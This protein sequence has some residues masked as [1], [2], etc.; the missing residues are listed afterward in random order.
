MYNKH[1]LSTQDIQ[2][3]VEI[4]WEQRSELPAN[5]RIGACTAINGKVYCEGEEKRYVDSENVSA[6][7]FIICYNPSTADWTTLPYLPIKKVGLGAINGQLV[8]VGGVDKNDGESTSDVYTYDDEL[9]R[10]KRTIPPMPT[11]RQSPSVLSL[12]SALIVAGGINLNTFADMVT[13]EV[14]RLD[15]SQWYRTDPLLVACRGISLVAIGD[16]CYALGGYKVESYLYTNQATYASISDLLYNA[17]PANQ[18]THSDSSGSWKTLT[19][20]PT[21]RPAAAVLGGNLLAVGGWLNA[22]SLSGVRTN[23][24]FTY[25][26]SAK[27]WIYIGDLPVQTFCGSVAALS[28]L[29]IVNIGVWHDRRRRHSVYKGTLTLR[30]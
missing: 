16:T 21:Y 29:E 30:F 10:W 12:Q 6:D 19:N 28:P 24:I 14:Y 15:T 22:E 4:T 8:A 11:D 3:K 26:P 13:V 20:T 7:A 1:F 5:I 17:V 9:K 2:A 25:S 23:K 27:S 18:T